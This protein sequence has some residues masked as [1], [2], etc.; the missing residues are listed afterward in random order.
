MF[1]A[2]ALVT[3]RPLT[4]DPF[5]RDE[6][7]HNLQGFVLSAYFARTL[8]AGA[9]ALTTLG[10]TERAQLATALATEADLVGDL[11]ETIGHRETRGNGSS[12]LCSTSTA[13]WRNSAFSWPAP[14][15]LDNRV[16]ADVP[17]RALQD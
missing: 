9:G 10:T 12:A 13:R 5:R 17:L 8:A 4:R 7:E 11:D 1:Q 3:A 16:G 15:R 14:D 2:H 6:L